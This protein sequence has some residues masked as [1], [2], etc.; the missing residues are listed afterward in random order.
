MRREQRHEPV[1]DRHRDDRRNRR[2]ARD[3]PRHRGRRG[4]RQPVPDVH[5]DE[6]QRHG[7]ASSPGWGVLHRARRRGRSV[8]HPQLGAG[9]RR[10]EDLPH[11]RCRARQPAGACPGSERMGCYLDARYR[12]PGHRCACPGWERTGCFPVAALPGEE[13]KVE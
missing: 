11:H 5:R 10:G 1:H 9:V 7:R 13:P 3:H 6:L 2:D 12:R 4:H 8:D